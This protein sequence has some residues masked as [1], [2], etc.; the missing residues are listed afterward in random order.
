MLTA[1]REGGF[2]VSVIM[3][4]YNAAATI[5]E[6]LECLLSQTSPDWEALVVDDGS[7]DRTKA[8]ADSFAAR[9]GRIRVIT[10]CNGGE[11]AARNHG[12]ANAR[13]SWLLFLDAD[14]WIAPSHL[15]ILTAELRANPALDAVHCGWARV[16]RD[17]TRTVEQYRPPAG[18]LFPVL[19]R[20]SAF[21][22]HACVV[23]KALV[24]A[25][26]AFD[27]SLCKSPDWD[28][29]QKLAR[30]GAVFGRVDDVL[31]FYRMAPHSASLEADQ[32]LRDGLVVLRRGHGP[33]ARVP[34]PS[35][36]YERGLTGVTIESQEYYLL[37][38]TAGLLLGAGEDA[39]RLLDQVSSDR[40]P[41]LSAD[42]VAQCLFEAGPLPSC[43]PP[44]GWETLWPT[45]QRSVEL[46][47]A[48][49]EKQS[50]APGLAQ[51]ALIRLKAKVLAASPTWGPV[52]EENARASLDTR[53]TFEAEVRRWLEQAVE[54][55]RQLDIATSDAE[56]SEFHL[57]ECRRK[58]GEATADVQFCAHVRE[59]ISHAIALVNAER[60]ELR[61]Q[62]SFA[63]ARSRTLDRE[64]SELEARLQRARARI[65]DVEFQNKTL[66]TE[67]QRAAD[68]GSALRHEHDRLDRLASEMSRRFHD[69][70]ETGKRMELDLNELRRRA[71]DLER[72]NHML[73]ADLERWRKSATE[74]ALLLDG[75]Q[76]RKWFRLGVALRLIAAPSISAASS[77]KSGVPDQTLPATTED[78]APLWNLA[79]VEGNEAS[80]VFP[81]E[82]HHLVRV[83]ISRSKKAEEPWHVQLNRPGL[84][85]R[86]GKRYLISYG[87][88]S[89]RSR[90]IRA[91]FA[92][93][94]DPWSNLGY[95]DIV[96]VSREWRT[97][98]AEFVARE[99]DEN[100]RIHFDL[101]GDTGAVDLMSIAVRPVEDSTES[102]AAA[103][104]KDFGNG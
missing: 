49:L 72:M 7:T 35:P 60:Q 38:W 93:A 101:G 74:R 21:P 34:S 86:A 16:A 103:G 4:A 1:P 2:P 56:L 67:M 3:P 83:V 42:A 52:M 85:S 82:D 47:L 13:Y 8:I 29:W 57:E 33:D 91:G 36:V 102:M 5:S 55:H 23:R 53:S 64:N 96:D 78:G 46:F 63:Q 14:D 11:G 30:S 44:S 94:H 95:H 40:Y 77:E 61:A 50:Q 26:G 100:A 24:D 75:L 39:R 43:D 65:S 27:T 89:D 92:M 81:A 32:M 51:D 88:R 98:S 99:D 66:E 73:I 28:L 76:R 25:V 31:A 97:V 12:I 58:G 18:D 71:D 41:E 6:S 45:A 17:G 54:L 59:E 9:D 19:A 70:E 22:I 90:T 104:G 20:R 48:A 79:L 87:V 62:A 10:R 37:C 80:I 68:Y 69:L 84:I 15:E